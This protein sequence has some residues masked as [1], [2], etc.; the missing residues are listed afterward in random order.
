MLKNSLIA[1]LALGIALSCDRPA[2]SASSLHDVVSKPVSV[3]PVSNGLFPADSLLSF[4]FAM[5][6]NTFGEEN[7]VEKVNVSPIDR[8][9]YHV[10]LLFPGSPRQIEIVL[11]DSTKTAEVKAVIIGSESIWTTRAGVAPGMTLRELQALNGRPFMFYGGGWD[12]GGY[13]TNWKDGTLQGKINSCRLDRNYIMPYDM[14]KGDYDA[15]EFSSDSR[16]AQNGNPVIEEIT[17]SS[18]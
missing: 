16:D 1:I 15:H 11:L 7:I 13:V 2:G 4:N 10:V 12:Q 14:S 9:N 8:T 5:L 6:A 3:A 18:F 17:L